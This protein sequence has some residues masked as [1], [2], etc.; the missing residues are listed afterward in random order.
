[1]KEKSG[2]PF[3]DLACVHYTYPLP[4]FTLFQSQQ[5]NESITLCSY[6]FSLVGLSRVSTADLISL[7]MKIS[8]FRSSRKV[9]SRQLNLRGKLLGTP[10]GLVKK[11]EGRFDLHP[12]VHLMNFEKKSGRLISEV[13]KTSYNE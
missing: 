5:R 4:F 1:M 2:S 13:F 11:G 12:G 6:S 8:L 3:L 10:H 7:V 9:L